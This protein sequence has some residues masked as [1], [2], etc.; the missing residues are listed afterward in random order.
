MRG[1]VTR[2]M[3]S[4]CRRSTYRRARSFLTNRTVITASPARRN[5]VLLLDADVSGSD[6]WFTE[7]V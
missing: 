5:A 2:A 6:S 4:R 1:T 7:R 3:P